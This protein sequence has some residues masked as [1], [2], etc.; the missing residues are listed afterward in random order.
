MPAPASSI[1]FAL[2]L[3]QGAAA[4]VLA[5]ILLRFARSY[6]RT[7]LTD[8]FASWAAWGVHQIAAA[9]AF[10]M[11]MRSSGAVGTASFLS[12]IS[13]AAGNLQA[14]LLVFGSVELARARPIARGIRGPLLA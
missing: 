12:G 3:A 4:L 5:G 2:Y 7:Y 10:S 13:L 6:H 11:A 9:L 14:L 8:W 1:V